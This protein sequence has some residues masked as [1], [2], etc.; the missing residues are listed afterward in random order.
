MPKPSKSAAPCT[1]TSPPVASPLPPASVPGTSSDFPALASCSSSSVSARPPTTSVAVSAGGSLA[2]GQSDQNSVL[3]EQF[4]SFLNCRPNSSAAQTLFSQAPSV[5]PAT[6]NP[7]P[8]GPGFSS[9]P[10]HLRDPRPIPSV[11]DFPAH[12]PRCAS[13]LRRS[14]HEGRSLGYPL[15]SDFGLGVPT[16]PF[17]V[18]FHRA[19]SYVDPYPHLGRS[20]SPV[21]PPSP[22]SFGA[23]DFPS[24]EQ[25]SDSLAPDCSDSVS[26]DFPYSAY[27]IAEE[28]RTLLYKYQGD[29]YFSDPSTG[30]PVFGQGG[31][32]SACSGLFMDATPSSVPGIA[33]PQEFISALRSLDVE[34]VC[35]A[36]PRG[37]KRAF[38]FTD[39]DEAQFFTDKTFS[40]DTL[41]FASSLRDPSA[42]S[43]P[44]PLAAREFTQRDRS[45]SS[46]AEASSVAARCAAYATALA[47]ILSQA[48]QLEVEEDDRSTI[49]NLLVLISARSFSEAMRTQ[50][51]V[52]HL[53]RHAALEALNLPTD[54]NCSAVINSPREGPFVFGQGFLSTIDSDIGMNTRAREVA[55][56]IR[57]RPTPY[58]R[59][60]SRGGSATSFRTAGSFRGPRSRG[61]SRRR[62]TRGRG[63]A[64]PTPT[65]S[66]A[67]VTPG[68]NFRS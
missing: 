39:E 60:P 13:S 18:P 53:R 10:G 54:F 30:A 65:G 5:P 22:R 42:S 40:P 48:D 24:A 67:P 14:A 58:R 63:F 33:L 11:V 8:T 1:V 46:V 66:A 20:L 9:F 25:S 47:D 64:Q 38:A 7:P 44:S 32:Q 62:S 59:R 4:L 57:P 43:K 12:Q 29:L 21:L 35:K 61:F 51:R 3:F 23:F 45:L 36:L 26:D 49:A 56:R 50:L 31:R 27:R 37:I 19:Q 16:T 68:G 17:G 15:R 2:G 34:N 52:T 41:A 28:A 55:R 6:A